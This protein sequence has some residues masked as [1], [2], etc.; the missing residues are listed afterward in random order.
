M[1]ASW[2][3]SLLPLVAVDEVDPADV[4]GL[5]VEWQHPLGSCDRPF[6]QQGHVLYTTIGGQPRAVAVTMSASIVSS[7]AAGYECGQV[8]ELARIARAPDAPWSMRVLLRLWRVLLA[9]TWPYWPVKAAVSY[10]LPGTP[11][12]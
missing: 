1:T 4:N 9:P 10:A 11:G 5:L 6:G 7:T 3:P 12:D 2:Q 8:V